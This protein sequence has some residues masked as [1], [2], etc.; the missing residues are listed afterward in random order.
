MGHA[1]LGLF[2][3]YLTRL[4][5]ETKEEKAWRTEVK[6]RRREF[7]RALDATN[8]EAGLY[9]AMSYAG[10]VCSETHFEETE[11][12]TV[13]RKELDNNTHWIGA[14]NGVV[15][16]L[17]GEFVEDSQEARDKLVV[18]MLPD[19]YNPDATHWAVDKLLVHLDAD[20]SAYLLKSLAYALRGYPS[21]T[22]MVLLG[23][24]GGGKTT[25]LNAI[26]HSL[27]IYAGAVNE[28][29][30]TRKRNNSQGLSPSMR[31]LIA[32]RRLAIL[33]EAN[34]V[35]ADT[36]RLKAIS[37]DG[38]VRWRDLYK[39]ERE[40]RVTATVL[41]AA[42]ELPQ[43]DATDSALRARM[44]VLP[45][46]PIHESSRDHSMR[47]IFAND[48]TARQALVAMII[49]AGTT[50]D[51]T[52]PQPPQVVQ[53]FTS[54]AVAELI[55]DAGVWVLE[56]LVREEGSKLHTQTLWEAVVE[57]FG[58]PNKY[59]VSGGTTRRKLVRLVSGHYGNTTKV[60][61]GGKVRRGWNGLE[62]R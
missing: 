44:R 6:Q 37:G 16:L 62:L 11:P 30:F 46:P 48:T 57:E 1:C 24:A 55:G 19:A 4:P 2:D 21:R 31:A 14:P 9:K 7:K 38:T 29:A 5:T 15:N 36:E 56:N 18:G 50:L 10:L 13:V 58:E 54:E 26:M 28:D 61:S 3:E 27:G 53:D 12:R 33:E 25:L 45:Y 22:F 51:D 41:M 39:S 35:I 49:A 17:T 42:N 59:G 20:T 60:R 34:R 23:G 47:Y 43:L 40:D 8:T 52:P 32:P